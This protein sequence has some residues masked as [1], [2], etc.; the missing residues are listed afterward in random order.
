MWLKHGQDT[1]ASGRSRSLQSGTDLRWVVCVIIHKQE[2][3]TLVL[4]FEPAA[5]VLEP[6]QRSR[7]L[8]EWNAKLGGKGD[9]SNGILDVVLSRN[10]QNR[11]TELPP[12]AINAKGRSKIT[13]LDISATI[14]GLL[15][16]TERDSARL[17]YA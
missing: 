12:F 13:Q 14:V 8:F 5:C 9:H 11:F 2:A 17:F 4:D 15:R 16:Q 3:I 10:I 7:N 1:F 6:A